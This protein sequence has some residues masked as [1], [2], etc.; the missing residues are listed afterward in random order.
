MN[1]IMLATK[2]LKH[3]K[4]RLF[5]ILFTFLVVNTLVFLMISIYHSA[6]NALSELG[7]EEKNYFSIY[8]EYDYDSPTVIAE[9]STISMMTY[10]FPITQD[11]LDKITSVDTVHKYAY[12]YQTLAPAVTNINGNPLDMVAPQNAEGI[13]DG[14]WYSKIRGVSDSELLYGDMLALKYGEHIRVE[15]QQVALVSTDYAELNNLNIGDKL[16][17]IPE[18]NPIVTDITAANVEVTIVGLFQAKNENSKADLDPYDLPEY[19]IYV[20]YNTVATLDSQ[21]FGMIHAKFYVTNTSSL[22]DTMEQVRNLDINWEQFFLSNDDESFVD[23]NAVRN[24]ATLFSLLAG[25][26]MFIGFLIITVILTMQTRERITEIGILLSLGEKKHK[27]MFQHGIEILLP[28]LFSLFIAI[29]ISSCI[30][31]FQD[32]MEMEVSLPFF[33]VSVIFQVLLINI[34]LIITATYASNIKLLNTS[35][36]DIFVKLS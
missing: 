24:I 7:Q 3:K 13:S 19:Y 14:S 8:S 22:D 17:L 29:I 2:Y 21:D 5:L 23:S 31:Y 9:G 1:T 20:D 11:I 28:A 25:I 35:P 10:P 26:T 27:I 18:E 16:I 4:N 36:R 6:N 33:Q 30:L 32:Y 34:I 12:E 15:A